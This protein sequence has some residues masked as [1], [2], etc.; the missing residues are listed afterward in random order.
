[1]VNVFAPR[2]KMSVVA[3]GIEDG[4]RW[5]V[6]EAPIKPAL[7]GYVELPDGHKW[8]NANYESCNADVHGGITFVEG[9]WI[10]FDTVHAG[11]FWT[12]KKGDFLCYPDTPSEWHILWTEEAVIEETKKLARQVNPN[13]H[14]TEKELEIEA[15]KLRLAELKGDN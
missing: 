8:I 15:L 5:S 6:C 10:G 2:L 3:C 13:F 4:I 7:N 12:T 9:N 11:D 1:M 14:K